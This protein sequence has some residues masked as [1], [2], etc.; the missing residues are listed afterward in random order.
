MQRPVWR[1]SVQIKKFMQIMHKIAPMRFDHLIMTNVDEKKW[2]DSKIRD[3]E[4]KNI[5]NLSNKIGYFFIL[6]GLCKM[7]DF[8]QIYL[9]RKYMSAKYS[10]NIDCRLIRMSR[11]LFDGVKNAEYFADIYF[12]IKSC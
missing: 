12:R 7:L 6:Y 1:N 4:L 3:E 11:S 8:K 2:I 9:I 5:Q 10:A